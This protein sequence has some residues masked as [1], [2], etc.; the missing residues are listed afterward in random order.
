[1]IIPVRCYSCNEPLAAKYYSYLKN[2][3]EL[4]QKNNIDNNEISS[5]NINEKEV[6]KTIEGNILDEIGIINQCCRLRM[7]T[8][9]EFH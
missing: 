5:I 1:M 2:V 9:I 6:K 4:K 3:A 8:H 7:L